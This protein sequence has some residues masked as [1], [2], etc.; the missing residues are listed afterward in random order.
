MAAALP[1]D[2]LPQAVSLSITHHCVPFAPMTETLERLMT[3]RARVSST[4]GD[5]KACC[6]ATGAGD[7]LM[8]Y[9]ADREEVPH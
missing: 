2:A 1:A 5:D 4:M 7:H 8:A 6:S 9:P 3:C